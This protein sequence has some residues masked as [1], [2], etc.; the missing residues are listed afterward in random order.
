M[1]E[2]IVSRLGQNSGYGPGVYMLTV[3]SGSRHARGMRIWPMPRAGLVITNGEWEAARPGWD[4]DQRSTSSRNELGPQKLDHKPGGIMEQ[5][6][7]QYG[8]DCPSCCIQGADFAGRL[9]ER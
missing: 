6:T 3:S 8:L 2:N 1:M 9:S 7:T 4:A 5:I